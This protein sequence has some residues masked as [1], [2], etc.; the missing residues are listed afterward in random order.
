M[1]KYE[2]ELDNNYS[3]GLLPFIAGCKKPEPTALNHLSAYLIAA[4][5]AKKEFFHSIE[6]D[7][8]ILNRLQCINHFMGGNKRV[9]EKGM[10]LLALVM[11]HDYK[12]DVLKDKKRGKYNPVGEGVWNYSTLVRELTDDITKFYWLLIHHLC[13]GIFNKG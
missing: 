8:N 7:E 12:K 13:F 4:K 11:I 2:I 3:W 6:N 9:L 5:G 10:K 1:L